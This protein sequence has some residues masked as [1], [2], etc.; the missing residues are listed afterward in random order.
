MLLNFAEWNRNNDINE[1]ANK[2]DKIIN[3]LSSNFGGSV[4]KI[5]S[6]LTKINKIETQYAKDWNEI[7]TDIDALQIQRAQ[8]KSD[9]AEAKKLDRLIDRNRKLVGALNKKKSSEI[10]RI[11]SKVEEITKDNPRLVSYWN[12][13]KSELEADL[14]ERL[15]KLAKQLTDQ[16]IA[17]ELYDKYK[18][19]ALQAK[20]KDDK[21]RQKFGKLDLAKPFE[22]PDPST[23]SISRSK[24]SLDPILAMNAVQFTK[25]AQGL[26]KNQIKD[27]IKF[28]T[29]ERNERYATLD[30]ERDRLIGQAMRKG[31]DKDSIDKDIK[32]LREMMMGQIRD[33]RT[34]ITI[35]RRYA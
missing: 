5:N 3:W 23:S 22:I 11:D 21:F 17:D 25:Y 8:T 1:S 28:M 30:T 18:E 20:E 35:A 33:L 27:L 15:Y 32:E 7:Q 14:T 13:K 2:T 19:A 31:L 26:E 12:L 16:D 10:G 29:T 4:A 24:F 6:L 9:P 34:K